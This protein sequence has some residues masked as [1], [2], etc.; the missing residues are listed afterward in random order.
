M[1]ASNASHLP[2]QHKQLPVGRTATEI[3]RKKRRE[4]TGFV[5]CTQPGET[6]FKVFL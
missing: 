1:E 6:K 2:P 5:S 3:K 4:E